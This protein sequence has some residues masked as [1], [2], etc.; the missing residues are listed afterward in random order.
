MPS[1][2]ALKRRRVHL[3]GRYKQVSV[4]KPH[5]RDS[6]DCSQNKRLQHSILNILVGIAVKCH[7]L[8]GQQLAGY[9]WTNK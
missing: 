3:G 9:A 1:G 6:G 8:Q 5:C 2:R 4:V 7:A